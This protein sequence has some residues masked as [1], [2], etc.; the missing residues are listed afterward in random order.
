MLDT[1]PREFLKAA[2]LQL[3][4]LLQTKTRLLDQAET[5]L[6]KAQKELSALK[7]AKSVADKASTWSRGKR[8]QSL[9]QLF[10]LMSLMASCH[11]VQDLKQLTSARLADQKISDAEVQVS[12]TY[13]STMLNNLHLSSL[14]AA[15][16]F[17]P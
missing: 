14:G 15:L 12:F 13:D 5:S 9:L 8:L 2:S 3:K 11:H 10:V 6:F 4:K 1:G 7:E 16:P 17:A